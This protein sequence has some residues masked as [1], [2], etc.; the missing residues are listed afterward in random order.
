LDT[1]PIF[2]WKVSYHKHKSRNTSNYV[3]H[4]TRSK[5]DY[6]DQHVGSRT[7]SMMHCINVNN[8]IVQNIFFPLHDVTV[9]R[10]HGKYPA[11]DLQ[12]VELVSKVY[13]NVLMN[14]KYH[15]DFDYLRKLHMLDKTDKANYTS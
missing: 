13:Q 1:K 14:T 6:K 4:R 2:V 8:L 7:R 5:A 11:K 12:L 9:F 10:G 3:A 15:I